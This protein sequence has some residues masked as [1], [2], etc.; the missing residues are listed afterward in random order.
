MKIV[1]C[2]SYHGTGSSALT[3]LI[4]E[5]SGV[6]SLGDYEFN[7]L[8]AV[9]GISDLEYHLTDFPDRHTSGHALKRF[10]RLVDFSAGKWFNK[11]YEPFFN[12]Q[13]KKL[14]Y[15]YIDKLIDFKIPGSTFYSDYDK[16]L[17]YYYS[18]GLINKIRH[19]CGFGSPRYKNEYELFSHPSKEQFL[20]FTREYTHNLLSYANKDDSKILMIDQLLPSSN[21][22]HCLRYLKD[23][24]IVFIVDRD[25]RDIFL[26][27]KY[28]WKE[29]NVPT[30]PDL[31]CKWFSLTHSCAEGLP[32]DSTRVMKVFFEDL[33]YNYPQTIKRIEQMCGLE[34]SEHIKMYC[35]LNPKKS[36]VNTRLWER[37]NEKSAMD[38]IENTLSKYLYPYDSLESFDVVGEDIENP[39]PF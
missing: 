35:K 4:T 16:G 2:A 7:F 19:L 3:D 27:N 9:D 28:V 6:C 5:Y 38:I 10:K 29:T 20:K 31:F 39:Q 12:N 8:Y 36:V 32:L 1:T 30:D 34:E 15:E 17:L 25:P 24:A 13:Y 26:I 18:K 14:S 11:R 22:M 21:T 33:I 37:Y 23:D